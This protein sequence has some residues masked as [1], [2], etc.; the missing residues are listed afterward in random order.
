MP[1]SHAKTNGM[2]KSSIILLYTEGAT[3]RKPG[4]IPALV[5]MATR[6]G[7]L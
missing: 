1:F 3:T 7:G 2:S 4:N 5:A 6:V